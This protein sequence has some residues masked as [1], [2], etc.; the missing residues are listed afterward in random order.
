[1]ANDYSFRALSH[2][3]CV[4]G[5]QINDLDQLNLIL[6]TYNWEPCQLILIW[7]MALHIEHCHTGSVFM[8]AKLK[9]DWLNLT[10]L[11]HDQE[12][13]Q[14][15]PICLMT[16]HL[17]RC[18]T[19]NVIMVAKLKKD[20]QNLTLMTHDWEPCQLPNMVNDSSFGA[21]SHYW[22][23]YGSQIRKD[24]Q[25]PIRKKAAEPNPYDTIGNLVS[26]QIWLMT[27]P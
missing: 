16:L 14:L 13:C 5:S 4:Y 22:H 11:T 8:V 25:N 19:R 6:M 3:Q 18:P 17:E 1:M 26:C 7:L 23:V 2:W 9:K 20:I 15:I 10:L 24:R 27:L 12:P 21:L